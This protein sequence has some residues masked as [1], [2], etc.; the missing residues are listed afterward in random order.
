MN[1]QVATLRRAMDTIRPFQRGDIPEVLALYHEVFPIM[2]RTES[3]N[4]ESYFETAF[5]GSPLVDEDAGSLVYRDSSG[6]VLGFL[7]V[8]PRRLTIRGRTLRAAVCTKFMVSRR[9][10]INA[11]AVNMLRSIFHRPLDLILAD[12]AN[13]PARRLWEG[14]GGRAVLLGSLYWSR[15]LR[16]VRSLVSRAGRVRLLKPLALA[17]RPFADI[18]D[19]VTTRLVPALNHTSESLD[20]DTLIASL[21]V[22]CRERSLRP[23]YDA[24]SL[25]WLLELMTAANPTKTLR[26]RL[27]RNA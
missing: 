5:F 21:P 4:L 13:D 16:P 22:V 10:G 26:K 23:D 18:A 3:G 24:R 9:A 7:G 11:A 2:E 25:K 12:L 17:A 27:V 8:Q 19:R 15:A 14:L 20:P 6:N 1:E